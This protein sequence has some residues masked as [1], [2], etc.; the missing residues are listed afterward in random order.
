MSSTK[1][2]F[3]FFIILFVFLPT[4]NYSQANKYGFGNYYAGTKNYVEISYGFG[5]LKH[6]KLSTP[7]FNAAQNEIILG[8][9]T[10][11][12]VAKYKLVEFSDSYLFSAYIDDYTDG[13][14]DVPKISYD[15]WKFGLGYRKGF[16]YRI[17]NM[18]ILPYYQ[19]GLVWNKMNINLPNNESSFLTNE[20]LTTLRYYEDQIKFGSTN[21]AGV[22]FRLSS[23]I[24][25]GASYET[26]I[27]FPY[28]KFWKQF[29]SYF[30]ETLA[31]TSLDYLT[32]GVIIRA[33]PELTPILYFVLKNGL[34]YY[35]YTLKQDEMN[36][37]FNTIAPL[38]METV[39]FSL[40]FS[41]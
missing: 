32:E 2:L 16:G 29:G 39:K 6:K 36:W 3:S 33:I 34:S 8:R 35:F 22:D 18:A 25:I 30:I 5:K 4:D 1:I 27:F 38:T 28:H 12:P 11:K 19:M 15:I 40:K 13:S 41:I 17:N 9:T 21:I 14:S 20:E 37:P 7:F 31:Q 10:Y 23:F 26:T 24:G